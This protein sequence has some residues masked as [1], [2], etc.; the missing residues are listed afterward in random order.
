LTFQTITS[1]RENESTFILK[2]KE[3]ERT[4]EIHLVDV[5]GHERLRHRLSHFLP[6]AAGL[7][8][9][10][11]LV[12]FQDQLRST[13]EYLFELLTNKNI[14]G[15]RTPILLAFNKSDLLDEPPQE[16]ALVK[17]LEREIDELRKTRASMPGED[18]E[19][20]Q[21]G[22]QGE[23]FSFQQIENTIE[24]TT[25]SVLHNKYKGVTDFIFNN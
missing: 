6:L 21:L 12:D 16:S 11:D 13:S 5:P 14:N 24:V 22:I 25:C 23:T 2:S 20:I 8:F 9:L 19:G 17:N 15:K 3:D 18:N 7:I 1:M 4:K 10:V